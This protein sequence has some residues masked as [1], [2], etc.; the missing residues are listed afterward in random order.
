MVILGEAVH[1]DYCI[2]VTIFSRHVKNRFIQFCDCLPPQ[3]PLFCIRVVLA[4]L[5]SLEYQAKRGRKD[6]RD[7]EERMVCV[8]PRD[9][10]A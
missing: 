9:L 1:P 7:L 10:L 3:I 8:V 5:G 4:T 6:H 2:G